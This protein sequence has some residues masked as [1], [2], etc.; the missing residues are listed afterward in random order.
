MLR[1]LSVVGALLLLGSCDQPLFSGDNSRDISVT[2]TLPSPDSS[3]IATLYRMSGGGAAGWCY[4]YVG[5]RRADQPF[6]PDSS[7]LFSTRCSGVG[8]SASWQSARRLRITYTRGTEA[9]TRQESALDGAI[10]ISYDER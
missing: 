8:I 9:F 6:Q 2:S 1:P 10:Q 3:H 5:G 7:I 4:Q